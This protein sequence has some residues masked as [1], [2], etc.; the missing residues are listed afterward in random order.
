YQE[1]K[2]E[3]A[4]SGYSA[5]LDQGFEAPELYY[6]LGNAFF[7][8]NKLAQAILNYERAMELDPSDPDIQYNLALANTYVIDK[9]EKL[10]EIF[11][12]RWWKQFT[13]FISSRTWA[14]LSV[15]FFILFLAFFSLYLFSIRIGV[16]K[17]SF[18]LSVILILFTILTFYIALEKHQQINSDNT[19]IIMTP[20]VTIKSSPDETS[21]DLFVLH[22][23]T[24]V[25]VEDRIGEWQ[26]IRIADG[27]KGWIKVSNMEII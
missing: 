10:P 19:A 14:I 20:S 6:N 5:I 16:K 11:Y 22:E 21:N 23:G 27:N 2:Y 3:E 13:G 12:I 25:H 1:G 8:S 4:I 26:E 15:T 17:T 18:V 9:I 7:K 24:K